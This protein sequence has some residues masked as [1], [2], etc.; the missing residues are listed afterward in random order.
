MSDDQ[1]KRLRLRIEGTLFAIKLEG[2]TDEQD[3]LDDVLLA[4]CRIPGGTRIDELIEK[5]PLPDR[6]VEDALARLIEHSQLML[7][8]VNGK[9]ETANMPRT[10]PPG[11][12]PV[13]TLLVWQD[14]SSGRLVPWVQIKRFEWKSSQAYDEV[15]FN[16]RG[17]HK[18]PSEMT[19]AEIVHRIARDDPKM[20]QVRRVVEVERLRRA[21]LLIQALARP[22]GR[23][24]VIDDVPS[25]LREQWAR[26]GVV[27]ESRPEL[28]LRVLPPPWQQ[29]IDAWSHWAAD[30]IRGREPQHEVSSVWSVADALDHS[31]RIDISPD[32]TSTT[33]RLIAGARTNVV[34]GAS[35]GRTTVGH[36]VG[37]LRAMRQGMAYLL[38]EDL[39]PKS[40]HLG[41]V[42]KQG[43]SIH[44]RQYRG[45]GADFV[46]IDGRLL[47]LGGLEPTSELVLRIS[48]EE[49]IRGWIAWLHG[50]G[51]FLGAEPAQHPPELVMLRQKLF[52][53]TAELQALVDRGSPLD[54]AGRE[55][56]DA[57]RIALEAELLRIGRAPSRWLRPEQVID[58]IGA[59]RS[60]EMRPLDMRVVSRSSL[61]PLALAAAEV[62]C[63]AL[64]WRPG[65]APAELVIL[66]EVV[67]MGLLGQED[68][69]G[70]DFL[71]VHDAALAAHLRTVTSRLTL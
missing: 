1:H 57:Q 66:D 32:G 35:N 15:D 8:V 14:L 47:V 48:S 61:S 67:V 9:V 45:A 38:L 36:A 12:G 64:F 56:Y 18:T 22:D 19:D 44:K 46:M 70:P 53:F 41:E 29:L 3:W 10:V 24:A 55:V 42:E 5:V 50:E 65:N 30:A 68:A 11:G 25:I 28:I 16:Y 63:E 20:A 69:E 37:L 49:P 23:H 13:S 2:E 62:G 31:V 7:D 59:W 33:R 39:E 17:L 54:A 43:W 71:A 21:P 60:P 4:V 51:V 27:R 52:R 6:L 58:L 26:L 34:I 40:K